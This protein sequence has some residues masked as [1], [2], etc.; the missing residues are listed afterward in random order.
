MNTFDAATD[1]SPAP[2]SWLERRR[3]AESDSLMIIKSPDDHA[4]AGRLRESARDPKWEVRK[5]VAEALAS[6]PEAL[7]RELAAKLA[8]DSNTMV[9]SAAERSIARRSPASVLSSSHPSVI[10]IELERFERRFGAEA[11]QEAFRLAERTAFLHV[12]TAVH[13]IK[14]IL[15]HF[16]VDTVAL[17]SVAPDLSTKSRLQRL[18]KGRQYLIRLVDMMEAYSRD[19]DL[20]WQ[21]EDLVEVA[22]ESIAAARDQVRNEG[23]YPDPVECEVRGPESII[24]PISR[25]HFAMVLTNLIKNAIQS[26]AISDK[27][28]RPGRVVVD[29]SA[30]DDGARVA[31][32]DTGRGIAPGD[33]QKLLDFVPGGSSKPGGMGYGLPICRRYIE[34]HAGELIMRSE[35]DKGTEVV[36]TLPTKQAF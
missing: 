5:V 22:N 12:R 15:T 17:L 3:R 2:I 32:I 21:V 33:L 1:S 10:Q 30:S 24:L 14:N 11:R 26:H 34:A 8:G 4:C 19:L 29:L 9:R 36:I 18:D 31:I 25:F 7:A 23:K 13:D 6:L 16:N 27:E 35:E 20:M 28:L